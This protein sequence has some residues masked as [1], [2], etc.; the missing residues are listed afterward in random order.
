MRLDKES[1][2]PMLQQ[3]LTG[4]GLLARAVAIEAI[5]LGKDPNSKWP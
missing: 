4:T 5:D 3:S 1:P 2:D